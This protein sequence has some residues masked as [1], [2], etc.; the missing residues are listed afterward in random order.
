MRNLKTIL[1]LI[2]VVFVA[3]FFVEEKT[4]IIIALCS[5]GYYFIE[6]IT[7]IG[8]DVKFMQLMQKNHFEEMHR[9]NIGIY[10]MLRRERLLSEMLKNLNDISEINKKENK[11]DLDEMSISHKREI[12]DDC[13]ELL[14]YIDR[15]VY[16]LGPYG[17]NPDEC[18][19]KTIKEMKE[20]GYY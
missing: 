15:E 7:Q 19:M 13:S 16:K 9:I 2:S 8:N 6:T 20:L 11:T 10:N 18:I 14:S 3:S 17:N 4:L 1:I 5:F 12:S